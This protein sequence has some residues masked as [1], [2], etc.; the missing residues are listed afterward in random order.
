MIRQYPTYVLYLNL[1][2]DLVDVNVHPSKM[3]VKFAIPA[4]IKK[5]V[6]DAIKEQV[7]KEVAIPKNIETQ[8]YN[9]KES[10]VKQIHFFETEDTHTIAK[11]D[12][13]T[14]TTSDSSIEYLTPQF[15]PI[16]NH[17]TKATIKSSIL[18]EIEEPI[19]VKIRSKTSDQLVR[20]SETKEHQPFSFV[21]QDAVGEQESLTI[22]STSKIVGKLFNTYILVENDGNLY[23]IDQ[24]AAHEKIIYDKYVLEFENRT[25]AKQSLLIS[26]DFSVSPDETELLKEKIDLFAKCGFELIHVNSN[27]FAIKSV[28]LCCSGLN[29]KSFVSDFLHNEQPQTDKYSIM[30]ADFKAK[31]MQSACKAAVKGE[32]ELSEMQINSLL[33]QMRDNLNELFCPHGRPIVIKISKNEIEKWFKRKV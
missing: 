21:L 14:N 26:Y 31:L 19:S 2:Y 8:Q 15:E 22:P 12:D 33:K 28:P 13:S 16:T 9:T 7:I 10:T 29:I 17:N 1:P 25:I 18:G 5:I 23:V 30:P 27:T 32:D 11:K 4:L 6:A 3:Q 20:L 24:H